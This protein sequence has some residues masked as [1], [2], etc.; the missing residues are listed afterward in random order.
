MA[1]VSVI[2]D[3]NRAKGCFDFA[4][5]GAALFEAGAKDTCD[6][7]IAV[8][9][10]RKTR[11]ERVKNRDG[12]DDLRAEQRFSMQKSEDFYIDNADY[13]LVNDNLQELEEKLNEILEKYKEQ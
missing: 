7:I 5:D 9:A 6:F 13:T 10:D 2:M 3:E 4:I 11:L 1:Q 8:V 12:I